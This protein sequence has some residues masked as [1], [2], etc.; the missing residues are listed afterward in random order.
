K[1]DCNVGYVHMGNL[2]QSDVNGMYGDLENTKAIIFDIRNYPNSTGSAIADLMYSNSICYVKATL[3]EINYP[4]T[5]Y[6]SW[7]YRGS[8]GNPSSYKGRVI[9]LCN[10]E[11]Q[12]HAE[13]TCMVFRA[14]ANSVI[15]GSQTAGADGN[16]S[17]FKL[18][19]DISTGFTSIGM[20]YPDGTET[21]RIGIVPDSFVYITP[22]GIRQGRDEVLE[23][24]LEIAG[25]NPSSGVDELN[26]EEVKL[27]VYPNPATD[28]VSISLSNFAMSNATLT[29]FNPIG[30]EVKRFEKNELLENNIVQ[31]SMESFPS[32]MYYCTLSSGKNLISHRFSVLR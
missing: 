27:V 1:W 4:G 29:I 7:Q 24:A 10:Q 20:F 32:G 14:M 16:V 28:K 25:C 8:N 18:S 9:I 26:L 12:S 22:N 31:F 21:Q 30:V 5:F 19:Q 6:W 2:S 17:V 11:T 15:V 13:W 3:P 23:K